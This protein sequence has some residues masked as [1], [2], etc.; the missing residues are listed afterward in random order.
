VS[1]VFSAAFEKLL[2]VGVRVKVTAHGPLSADE[3]AND[4]TMPNRW[5]S[6]L[7]GNLQ[8]SN[9]S[10]LSTLTSLEAIPHKIEKQLQNFLKS[11]QNS[12]P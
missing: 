2:G 1:R 7:Q 5:Q 12:I 10:R 4:N 8:I 3:S 9:S 11:I 6:F